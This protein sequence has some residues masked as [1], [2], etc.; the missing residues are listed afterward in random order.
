MPFSSSTL[1]FLPD[2]SIDPPKKVLT[3]RM[4]YCPAEKILLERN[5]GKSTQN[6]IEEGTLY[7]K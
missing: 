6:A 2:N 3:F 1:D 5:G 4:E 7:K